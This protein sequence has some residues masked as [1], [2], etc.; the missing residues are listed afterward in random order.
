[1][2]I[3]M[4]HTPIS[5]FGRR[6][7]LRRRRDVVASLPARMSRTV[8]WALSHNYRFLIVV[9]GREHHARMHLHLPL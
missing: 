9:L 5:Y 3:S 6:I 7:S 1:M 4:K 8:S 2:V